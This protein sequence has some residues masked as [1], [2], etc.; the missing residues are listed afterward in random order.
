M[1]WTAPE[2]ERVTEGTESMEETPPESTDAV[3]VDGNLLE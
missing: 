3:D 2:I 1:I